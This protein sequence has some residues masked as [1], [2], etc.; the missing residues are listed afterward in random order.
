[1]GL[2]D[3]PSGERVHIGLFGCRNAGKSSIINAITGQSLAIVSDV[4]GTTT[5]P[6][7]KAMELL[8]LGPVMIIDTPGL[9]DVG[10]LGAL[11]MEKAYQALNKS[12]IALLIVD[13]EKGLEHGDKAILERIKEKGIPYILVFNKADLLTSVPRAEEEHTIYVS[14]A[15]KVNIHELKELIASRVIEEKDDFPIIGD[16]IHPGDVVV[17]VVPVDSAAPK[18]RLILPQQQTI[19]EILDSGANAM[20]VQVNALARCLSKLVDPPRLVVTDSQAFHQVAAIVPKDMALTS[21]SI[22]FARHKGRLATLAAGAQFLDSLGDGDRILIAEGC[23]HHRQCE[24]IGTVKL[25]KWLKQYSG[26]EL[27]FEFTAGTEFPRDLSPYNLVVHCGGCTL[28]RREMHHR[29]DSCVK[30]HIPVTNYG[31]AI[32]HLHGILGRCLD[33]FNLAREKT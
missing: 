13:S 24:D 10:S 23:T 25:P 31:I 2:N 19:R 15:T 11:R 3:T 16:L 20:V 5:D 30:A 17:L 22:L 14:A 29:I 1:M 27:T 9:D 28:N 21:F 18:G 8:P 7:Y 33:V 32:S 26:K 12:D 6:V 4:K